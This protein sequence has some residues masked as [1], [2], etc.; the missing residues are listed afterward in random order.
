MTFLGFCALLGTTAVI[1]GGPGSQWVIYSSSVSKIEPAA[2]LLV[3]FGVS[4]GDAPFLWSRVLLSSCLGR[5][6]SRVSAVIL[7]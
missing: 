7:G 4:E 3:R 1:R 5:G 6:L 2:Q